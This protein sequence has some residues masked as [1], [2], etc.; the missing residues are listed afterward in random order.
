MRSFSGKGDDSS[1]DDDV[2]Q[3]DEIY[4]YTKKKFVYPKNVDI[5]KWWQNH[6]IIYKQPSRLVLALLSIPASSST[7]ERIFSETGRTL[8]TRRQFLSPDSY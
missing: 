8:E 4:D 1:D 3:F 2:D 5:L 6:S 7:S